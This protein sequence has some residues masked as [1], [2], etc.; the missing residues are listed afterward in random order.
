MIEMK[1]TSEL[2]VDFSLVDS[3]DFLLNI[4]RATSPLNDRARNANDIL[5]S[6]HLLSAADR[7]GKEQ[8]ASREDFLTV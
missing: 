1:R 3:F 6:F 7:A 8:K 4:H 2:E 5:L